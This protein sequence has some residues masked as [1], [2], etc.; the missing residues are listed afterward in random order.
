MGPIDPTV[1]VVAVG[2]P[3]TPSGKAPIVSVNETVEA[4]EER[5]IE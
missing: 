3:P 1:G 4:M 2:K 5:L